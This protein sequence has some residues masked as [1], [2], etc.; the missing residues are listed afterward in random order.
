MLAIQAADSSAKKSPVFQERPRYR[1][2]RM[3]IEEARQ[4]LAVLQPPQPQPLL[5]TDVDEDPA[6][7]K[8]LSVRPLI[9]HP[10]HLD[11]TGIDRGQPQAHTL[12]NGPTPP[13]AP[14][15]VFSRSPARRTLK[16]SSRVPKSDVTPPQ[17]ARP[18]SVETF[19]G[20]QPPSPEPVVESPPQVQKAVLSRIPTQ[21]T[22]K[23]SSRIQKPDVAPQPARP[24]SAESTS[25][26]TSPSPEPVVEPVQPPR[27]SHTTAFTSQMQQGTS[28]IPA[29]TSPLHLK[30]R[31]R[32][33]GPNDF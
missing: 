2:V 26:S 16:P 8:P 9:S 27:Q 19:S 15:A 5:V 17:P 22:L 32:Q 7:A 10:P 20:S 28:S 21:K 1:T 25:G 29:C 30:Y 33:L 23:L 14:K 3:I 6:P 4:N 11:V 12:P 31:C 18:L 13:Q 24:L